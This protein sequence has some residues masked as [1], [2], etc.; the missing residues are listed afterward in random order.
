MINQINGPTTF[1]ILVVV[2]SSSTFC[3]LD[4]LFAQQAVQASSTTHTKERSKKSNHFYTFSLIMMYLLF[5]FLHVVCLAHRAQRMQRGWEDEKLELLDQYQHT[6]STNITP[7][8]LLAFQW[9]RWASTL[10]VKMSGL[11]FTYP[12]CDTQKW[13]SVID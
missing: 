8:I 10:A 4:R 9:S 12:V 6:S 1:M 5:D 11:L 7:A 2:R 3:L 13:S